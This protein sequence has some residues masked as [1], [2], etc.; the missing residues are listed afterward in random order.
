[1]LKPRGSICNLDCQ[2]CFY[3][4]KEK[5]YPGAG[6]RMNSDILETYTRQ[7]IEAQ[8][9]SEV[10]FAWQGGEPTLMGLPFFKEAVE[11]Q[12]KYCKGGM[13]IQN[14]FQTNGTLLNDD[15]CKF[16]YQNHFLIG[17]S[18]DGPRHSTMPTD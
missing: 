3:L 4:K 8:Q 1:M 15:W 11:L 5:L 10:V 16:F 9:S 6:F 7:Y 2:Y 17:L 12:A 14:A 13:R 18:I